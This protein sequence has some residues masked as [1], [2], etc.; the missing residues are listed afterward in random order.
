MP[1]IGTSPSNGVRRVYSYTATASQTT[2]SGPSTEGQ[3]L[4]YTDSTYIDV[5]QNGVLL[6][7][8]DYTSTNGTEVELDTGAAVNDVVVIIV[9]D[10]FSVADTV[11]KSDGGT[12]DGNVTMGGTLSVTG[13]TTFSGTVTGAG[14][15]VK[16]LE[17]TDPSSDTYYDI[18]S[19]YINSTYDSYEIEFILRSTS[20][21]DHLYSRV[22]VGGTLQTGSIYNFTISSQGDTS[23]DSDG[24]GQ[25]AFRMQRFSQGNED[26]AFIGGRIRLQNVNSTALPYFHTG[27]A[28]C[29]R[30]SSGTY[31][32]SSISGGLALA[33]RADV[34]NGLRFYY[35]ANISSDGLIRVYGIK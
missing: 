24:A 33:N 21:N 20:D 25:T 28:V 9:Y 32:A 34:V 3:T 35:G 4:A 10:V 15:M 14:S 6:D 26:G 13:A 12:F 11:S 7:K 1:Y 18:D 29:Y 30:Y 31:C 2:F 5:Y 23:N 22:F 19:T 27:M 8:S 16:L 17:V